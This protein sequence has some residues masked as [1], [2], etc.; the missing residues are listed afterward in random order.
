MLKITHPLTGEEIQVA[1][2]DFSNQMDWNNANQSCQNLGNGW[3][4]PTMEELTAMYTQLH[5]K[6]I[7]NF[8][9]D[10]IYWSNLH[11]GS[12]IGGNDEISD[13]YYFYVFGHE[14]TKNYRERN[15]EYENHRNNS[16]SPF[17]VR[18]VRNIL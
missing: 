14:D 1:N 5:L 10:K 9:K 12:T 6:R 17:K 13:Y 11:Y 8:S 4:L 18:A 2:A 16:S 7:G 15:Y 3:R